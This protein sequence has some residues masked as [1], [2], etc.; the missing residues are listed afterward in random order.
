MKWLVWNSRRGKINRG[1]KGK[2]PTRAKL[3]PG[4]AHA[5]DHH[6]ENNTMLSM[7]FVE[8]N[9]WLSGDVS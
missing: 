3:F 1:G 4:H 5:P 6:E 8:C 9:V 7:P 2:K